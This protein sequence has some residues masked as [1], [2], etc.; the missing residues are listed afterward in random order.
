MSLAVTVVEGRGLSAK[1]INGKSDPYVVVHAADKVFESKVVSKSLNPIWNQY[2]IADFSEPKG[3]VHVEVYDHD[4]VSSDE[5][6]G[7]FSF[8]VSDHAD[9]KLVDKW[10]KLQPKKSE[11]VTGEIRAKIQYFKPGEKAVPQ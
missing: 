2:F 10:F 5:H 8:N 7:Q 4:K 6:M 9:G 1:D 3:I 11:K